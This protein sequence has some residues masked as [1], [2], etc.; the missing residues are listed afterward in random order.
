[1]PKQLRLLSLHSTTLLAALALAAP[2]WAET[3]RASD[4]A[5]AQALFDQGKKLMAE[6]KPL[7]ACPKFAESQRL[8]PGV[9]TLL[10][11]AACHEAAGQSA[12]AWSKFLEAESAAR[13]EGNAEAASVA[14]SRAEALAP[15]LSR[16]VINVAG[17]DGTDVEVRRDDVIVGRAQWGAP[18]PVDPGM[19][20][21]RATAPNR[22]P[23]Q[24]EVEVKGEGSSIGL[25]IPTLRPLAATAPTAPI[26]AAPSV[27]PPSS[28]APEAT[29]GGLGT[30]RVLAIGAG[31][32]GVAGLAFGTVFG[33]KSQ[34]KR[35]NAKAYC[36]ESNVCSEESGVKLRSEAIDA[37][38][39]STV[40]FIVGAV[41]LAGGALLWLSAKPADPSTP[42]VGLGPGRFVVRGVF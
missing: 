6:G 29:S 23:W 39:L 28:S 5:A 17:G 1:M 35:D 7:Q 21:I 18:I 25:T 9:G 27:P 11:L 20:R 32:V 4:P 10:N 31:V 37:G 40:G 26:A 8:D 16:I 30:T 34:S 41:G 12:S 38:N 14:R 42:A 2:A 19:H 33:L 36:D 15:K 3:P 22:E 13:A 24:H